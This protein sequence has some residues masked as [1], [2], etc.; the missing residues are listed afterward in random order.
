MFFGFASRNRRRSADEEKLRETHRV[1]Y[2]SPLTQGSR[3]THQP[4]QAFPG[5]EGGTRSVTDEGMQAVG[6]AQCDALLCTIPHQSPTLRMFFGFAQRNR[7]RSADEEKLR[8][9]H[10]VSYSSPPREAESRTNPVR[11]EQA[12][13]LRY[14][15]IFRY[16]VGA[17]STTR[18][19]QSKNGR[20]LV[21]P[22]GL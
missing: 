11:R 4:F 7:R 14:V 15:H 20:P 5:G 10:R 9:T 1:S 8:E 6:T 2:S 19:H 22:T 18:P 3:I 12:P 16:S 21:A 17:T 13:A